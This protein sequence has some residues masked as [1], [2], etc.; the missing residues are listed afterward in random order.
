MQIFSC[1]YIFSF[2]VVCLTK[3]LWVEA[4]AV[5]LNETN[6]SQDLQC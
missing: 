3:E 4:V 2:P 6:A 5:Y 1:A